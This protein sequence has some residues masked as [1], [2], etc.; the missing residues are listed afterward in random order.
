MYLRWEQTLLC[1][2]DLMVEWFSRTYIFVFRAVQCSSL[3]MPADRDMFYTPTLYAADVKPKI[4]SLALRKG[5]TSRSKL[6]GYGS[7]GEPTFLRHQAQYILEG[8]G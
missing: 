6:G 7:L 3:Y 8:G 2:L 5:N 1:A 4:L